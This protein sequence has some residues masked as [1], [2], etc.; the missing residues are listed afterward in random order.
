VSGSAPAERWV[1]ALYVNGASPNS[2]RAIETVRRLCE[3]EFGSQAELEIIDAQ[4]QPDLAVHDHV[5]A[6][7]TLIRRVPGPV[8]RIVGDLSD[9]ARVRLALGLGP[10]DADDTRTVLSG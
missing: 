1:L 8:R 9:S 2:I 6:V 10:V 3:E 5:V 4:Q 7:P